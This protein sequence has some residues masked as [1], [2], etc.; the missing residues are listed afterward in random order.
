MLRVPLTGSGWSGRWGRLRL[1]VRAQSSNPGP[2]ASKPC[3]LD[4]VYATP[5]RHPPP[6]PNKNKGT[7]K[8]DH[9]GF[10]G[11]SVMKNQLSMQG[12]QETWV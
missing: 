4:Q 11:G 8:K 12:M 3:D 1:G 5:A 2:E 7:P 10:P 9:M 6:T